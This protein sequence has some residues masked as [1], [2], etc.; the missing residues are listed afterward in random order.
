MTYSVAALAPQS[1]SDGGGVACHCFISRF[2]HGM[3]NCIYICIVA[4]I[5]VK[6][7]YF[8]CYILVG[9]E[10]GAGVCIILIDSYIYIIVCMI[11]YG[12]GYDMDQH[13]A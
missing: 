12:R 7:K 3:F 9:S 4:I 8:H 11:V 13:S 6:K 10:C 5:K 2:T 1:I